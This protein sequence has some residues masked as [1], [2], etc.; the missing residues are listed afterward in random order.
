MFV[1]LRECRVYEHYFFYERR[2]LADQLHAALDK[3]A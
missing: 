3:L 1:L 2:L